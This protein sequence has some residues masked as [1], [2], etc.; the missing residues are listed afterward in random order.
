[1]TLLSANPRKS[2]SELP[3]PFRS[4]RRTEQYQFSSNFALIHLYCVFS[5]HGVSNSISGLRI[6]SVRKSHHIEVSFFLVIS[7]FC[8]VQYR[9]LIYRF[10]LLV[11]YTFV[12]ILVSHIC[13][14]TSASKNFTVSCILFSITWSADIFRFVLSDPM[15]WWC[16]FCFLW[17]QMHP[18]TNRL[19]VFL[20]VLYSFYVS[21]FYHVR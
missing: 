17:S 7:L 15:S 18:I 16:K 9:S 14:R 21:F 2:S 1:M 6:V 8:P 13:T 12:H 10:F 4:H 20:H 11:R 5:A 19:W 3:P